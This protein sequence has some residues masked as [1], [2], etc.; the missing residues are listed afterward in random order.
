MDANGEEIKRN[1]ENRLKSLNVLKKAYNLLKSRS[2]WCFGSYAR[3]KH[4]N[5]CAPKNP[6]ATNWCAIGALEKY[7]EKPYNVENSIAEDILTYCSRKI[8]NDKVERINDDKSVKNHV[9]HNRILKIYKMAI[10]LIK[11]KEFKE[12]FNNGQ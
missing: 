10:L 5:E 3:T 4:G 6:L 8:F 12:W 1:E 9:R 2:N 11:S 7:S